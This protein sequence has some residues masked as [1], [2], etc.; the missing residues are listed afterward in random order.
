MWTIRDARTGVQL[1]S[2][3]VSIRSIQGSTAIDRSEDASR[4]L[5]EV[6]E[7]R[8][9]R[10]SRLL[11]VVPTWLAPG[12]NWGR[13]AQS[14][15]PGEFAGPLLVQPSDEARFRI[16]VDDEFVVFRKPPGLRTV[17]FD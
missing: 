5:Q 13:A 17:A 6:I 4:R 16:A 14:L 8:D 10:L 12:D 2:E 7:T 3:T 1:D 9:L 11:E 15:A